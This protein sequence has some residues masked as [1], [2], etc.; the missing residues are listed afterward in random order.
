[1]DSPARI[2]YQGSQLSVA[3]SI[4]FNRAGDRR[5][6]CILEMIVVAGDYRTPNIHR[7]VTTARSIV[8]DHGVFDIYR[9][10]G[11]VKNAAGR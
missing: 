8:S 2:L 6:G 1:M 3:G 7:Q 5:P 11:G 4:I 10:C 9:S